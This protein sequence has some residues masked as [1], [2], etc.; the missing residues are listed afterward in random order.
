MHFKPTKLLLDSQANISIVHPNLLRDIKLAEKSVKINGVGGHQFYVK[1]TGFLD[2]FFRVYVSEETR[3]NILSLAEVEDRFLVL[4]N[5]RTA[6][7][8]Y[9]TPTRGRCSV[10]P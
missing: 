9:C 1:E 8:F 7:E 5:L 3:A 4:S 2:P 10:L 6:R